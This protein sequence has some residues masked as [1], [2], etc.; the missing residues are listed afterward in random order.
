MSYKSFD[1]LVVVAKDL[2]GNARSILVLTGAGVSAESGVPTFRSGG[3]SLIW[4]G[5]PFDQLSSAAM[6]EKDLPLV[7]EWFDYR[8]GILA[9]CRPNAAHVAIA[10]AQQSG[11][12]IEFAL[13]TQNVDG[14]HRVAGS[15]N[16]IEL[17][18]S[19]HEARCLSC[20]AIRTL[21]Q[22]PK[23][24]RPPSCPECSDLMRPN[25][26]LFGE[27][28]DES[29][30]LTSCEKA[31]GCD[32]CLVVGTSAVVYP[33]NQIPAIAKRSGAA[34]IE[35]NPEETMLTDLADVSIRGAAGEI[36][37]KILGSS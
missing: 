10:E 25:V 1:E 3:K 15:T 28:L 6:V 30:I 35:V 4:R 24:E 11:R 36:I 22:L 32:A 29:T 34:V 7:W 21:D 20:R 23:N 18:G 27:M 13:V 37:P 19:I 9:D 12:F 17:H 33:A 31:S 2:I 5:M 26:V 14:L 8:R 16:I